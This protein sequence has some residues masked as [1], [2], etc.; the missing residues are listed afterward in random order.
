LDCRIKGKQLR[1]DVKTGVT[2]EVWQGGKRVDISTSQ[3]KR[4][5]RRLLLGDGDSALLEGEQGTYKIDVYRPPLA[6]IQEGFSISKRFGKIVGVALVIHLVV[7]VAVAYMQPKEGAGQEGQ[8]EETFAD[9]KMDAPEI[10]TPP[11]KKKPKK[12]R[13]KKDTLAMQ[14]K[15]PRVTAK[16]VR[17]ISRSKISK[18]ASV[19]SLLNVL[20][21]GSGTPGKSDSIKDLVSNIDAVPSSKGKGSSFGIAGA[22]ASLPGEGVNI[23]RKGG[24]GDVSTMSGDEVAGKGTGIGSLGKGKRSGN[25]R[26]KV[27]KMSSGAKVGGSLSRADVLRVINSNLHAIQACYER[28]LM[29][30]PSLSGRIAFD[31]TVTSTGKVKGVRVRSSTLGSPKVAGC[32]SKQIKRWKFPRPKGGEAKITYPF[33]FRSVSS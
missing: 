19:S 6:P 7:G 11:E 33:L 8:A 4:G 26:G 22:I 3:E 5:T 28:A 10:K 1:L 13:R 31:W 21:K 14:E 20:S 30:T 32:I 18:S 25:V 23:A 12:I 15:A 27:T 29:S 2:G 9:V 24:G 17:K 16:S